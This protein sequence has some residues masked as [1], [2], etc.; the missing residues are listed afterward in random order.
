[1]KSSIRQ[2]QMFFVLVTARPSAK[3]RPNTIEAR[4]RRRERTAPKRRRPRANG[5]FHNK[6]TPALYAACAVSACWLTSVSAS[7]LSVLSVFFSSA[8]VASSSF[9]ASLYPSSFAQV[10]SVP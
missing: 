1:M 5:A 10:F 4:V 3:F 9:T 8:S 2:S 7:L 6:G